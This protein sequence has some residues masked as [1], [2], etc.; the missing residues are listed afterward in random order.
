MLLEILDSSTSVNYSGLIFK[1]VFTLAL[2]V[3]D[4]ALEQNILFHKKHFKIFFSGPSVLKWFDMTATKIMFEPVRKMYIWLYL[5]LFC[6][7]TH[8]L[9]KYN[10]QLS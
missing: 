4:V 8:K 3:P 5:L 2:H 10:F 9:L 1:N 7:I 6:T